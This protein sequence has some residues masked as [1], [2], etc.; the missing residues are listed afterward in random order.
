MGELPRAGFYS[1]DL[2]ERLMGM[3]VSS[4]DRLLPQHQTLS[5]GQ[6]LDS[7]GNML[8]K[9]VEPEHFL[10]LGPPDRLA[11]GESTWALGLYPIEGGRSRLVSRVRAR[12]APTARGIGLLLLLDPGQ[13]L[14]ER[15]MLLGIKQ[16][17]ELL[18]RA[19]G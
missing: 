2:I 12:I 18:D 16:R 4:A 3:S 11:E 6:A 19:A 1:Y 17:A 5:V 7:S 13:F 14:M 8:V 9:A 15:R 10:I